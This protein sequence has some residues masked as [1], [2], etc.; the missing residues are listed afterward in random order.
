MVEA[1]LKAK[2]IHKKMAIIVL[3]IILSLCF[4]AFIFAETVVLKSGQ[5]I[6]GK[7][8][9]QGD[10]Y[11]KIDF[12]GVPITYWAKDIESIG[13]KKVVLL[14]EV[15][16]E[17]HKPPFT[18]GPATAYFY[19]ADDLPEVFFFP[20]DKARW[21]GYRILTGSWRYLTLYQK[22]MFV[23]EAMN[24]IE[25]KE[26]TIIKDKIDMLNL[27]AELDKTTYILALGGK[28]RFPVIGLIFQFLQEA[29]Y[30]TQDSQGNIAMHED[31]MKKIKDPLSLP[32]VEISKSYTGYIDCYEK[33]N[34]WV[35]PPPAIGEKVKNYLIYSKYTIY[36]NGSVMLTEQY[37]LDKEY[38]VSS[39]KEIISFPERGNCVVHYYEVKFELSSGQ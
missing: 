37:P 25:L 23:T 6:E 12:Y 1:D 5:T 39:L 4:P 16:K 17:L 33:D 13:G 26:H 11:I 20:V 30:I 18:K 31:I 34:T 36:P 27:I 9:E 38:R 8:I 7:M 3:I 32:E 21:N 2:M 14:S 29:G 28:R 10:D 24:E 19:N 15:E 35:Y 22:I